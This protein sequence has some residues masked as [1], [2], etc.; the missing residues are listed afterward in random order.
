MSVRL[1]F[2]AAGLFALCMAWAPEGMA[3]PPSLYHAKDFSAGYG[4]RAGDESRAVDVGWL[5]ERGNRV[6]VNGLISSP[7]GLASGLGPGLGDSVSIPGI[8]A[9]AVGNQ[10]NVV[11]EGSWNTIIIDAHQTNNAKIYANINYNDGAT[12]HEAR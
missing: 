1:N 5:G 4:R 3:S 11:A 9:S 7:S 6:I 10:I 8:T 12:S 2:P